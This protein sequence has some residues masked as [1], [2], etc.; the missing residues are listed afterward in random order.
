MQGKRLNN[1]QEQA[2]GHVNGPALVLA[3]P[4][5]GKTTVITERTRRLIEQV[6][7]R[8]N[9]ILV[10]TFTKAAATEMKERF[11]HLMGEQYPVSF[12][13]FH[14]VFFQILKYAYQYR[15]ENIIRDEDKY[16][17]FRAL[18]EKL[19]LEPGEEKEFI[20]NITG[21]ISIVKGEMMDVANYYPKC[22]GKEVFEEIYKGYEQQLRN[23]NQIDFDDM[24]LMCYELLSARSDILSAWQN[25][26]QYILIDEF[27]DISKV[28]Y[29]V[30]RMLALPQ[31]NLFI[32]GDDDQS[33]YRFR[34]AKPEI[35]LNFKKDYPQ[36]VEIVLGDNYRS[37]KQIVKL[38]GRLI[39]NNKKRFQKEIRA[40][41][42]ND[43]IVGIQEFDNQE[44]ENEA[45]VQL[46][47]D[48][49][50]N[51]MEYKDMAVLFRTNTGPRTLVNRLMEFNIPFRMKDAMPNIYNHWI[52]K[53]IITYI[54]MALGDRSRSSFL[55][56]MNRPKRYI[57]RDL[58]EETEID[59]YF[60]CRKLADKPWMVERIEKLEF[61]LE[62]LA[63]MKPFQAITYIRHA[64]GYEEYLQEYAAFRSM[65]VEP[66]YETLGEI[67][68]MSKEYESFDAWFHHI[69]EYSKELQQQNRKQMQNKETVE[70]STLHGAKGLEYKVVIIPDVNEG[71]IPYHKAVLSEELEEERRLLYVGM[72]R[73]KTDLYLFSVKEKFDKK[74]SASRF[75]ADI[76]VDMSALQPG[77]EIV[78]QKYGKG[79]IRAVEDGKVNIWFPK[80][81][82]ELRFD[83]KFA[84]ANHI[85]KPI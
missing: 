36:A 6:G 52:A 68:Q 74:I 30:I 62:M 59:Y 83:V 27:Q 69:D 72:T 56:I 10:I 12:G 13:T 25:K 3:G 51:G 81:R 38:A 78:H 82:K 26:Y 7:V 8:P 71:N 77:C 1:A 33:I 2:A 63:K 79:L 22:C 75:L 49:H 19:S 65:E 18:I 85:I 73:A 50:N 5:S 58:L 43:G 14:A 9:H 23:R 70:I 11:Y 54:R 41:S 20:E 32:V 55:Q 66:L 44:V 37:D 28:Q 40:V 16:Q 46:I 35:M 64:I 53:N 29:E 42:E 76:Q 17:I 47:Q 24:L 34:G 45:V 61:D 4:G 21:E 60:L 15:A 67:H 48:Y 39:A 80:L 84:L 57:S 31:N